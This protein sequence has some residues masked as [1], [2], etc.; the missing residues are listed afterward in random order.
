[1]LSFEDTVI[2]SWM[3]SYYLFLVF[4]F[5]ACQQFNQKDTSLVGEYPIQ[6]VSFTQVH[7]DDSFWAPR[8][9][10]HR[11]KTL[12]YTLDQ[13]EQTG[14]IRNFQIAAGDTVGVF[15]TQFPFDDSDL[16][17]I[18][19][20]ASY[21]LQ[22]QPDAKLEQRI[23]SLI[24]L[25]G[26][27][28]E[29][30]GYLYT[31][32]TIMGEKGHEWAGTERWVNTDN[33]SHELYNLGHLYEA[34]AA[35]HTAT[36]K[37]TLLNIAL[38]SA[39]LVD[40][41]FGWGKLEKCPGHQVIEIGLAK[42]YRITKDE[43]YLKLAQFFLD[44]R[45]P[46][47]GEYSQAHLKVVEQ[48]E[49][50]GHAVRAAYMY[51]GMADIAALTGNA[52]YIQA[53]DAIWEDVVT[54]KI[55]VTGGIGSTGAHEGFGPAY[56]LPNFNAYCETC[57]SIA[58]VYWNHR[59]FLMHGEGKYIDVMERTLYNAAVAG[60]GLSGDRFFYPNVLEARK[61]RERSPWFACACCP[62]SVARFIPS[63]AGYQYGQRGEDI[64]VNLYVGGTATITLGNQKVK[65]TQ[66][67]EYPFSGTIKL[68]VEPDQA[69][70]FVLKLRIPG[71][72]Q[73]EIIPGGLYQTTTPSGE[74]TLTLNGRK[75]KLKTDQGY[76]T[77]QRKWQA[78][79]EV[80]LQLPM[81]VQVVTALDSVEDDRGKVALQ[82]GPL[83]YC[84]EGQDQTDERVNNYYLTPGAFRYDMHREENLLGGVTSIT[85][86]VQ[87]AEAQ[88]SGPIKY[89]EITA[90]AIPYYAWANRTKDNMV[91]WMA[92]DSAAVTPVLW[93]TI[94]SQSKV[95]VS[96]DLK[97]TAAV[98]D[99]FFPKSSND[100]SYPFLHWWP[101]FGQKEWIQ[102]DFKDLA[103]I[104]RSEIYWF[105][106]SPE[107]GCRIPQNYQLVYQQGGQWK[108]VKNSGN[109]EIIKDQWNIVEFEPIETKSIR[110][111]LKSQDSVSAG[112]HE[113]VIK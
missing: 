56:H 40:R 1:M 25:I 46:D 21:A 90:K 59:L 63:I 48:R 49:A 6:P 13:C 28:Q 2:W 50:V 18:I 24:R 58:N 22:V 107:G 57:A 41:V 8:M 70:K 79:D 47:K 91:V 81:P 60:L 112:I 38:K 20:G 68:F 12:A 84:L 65:L 95:S 3:K 39:D 98:N 101:R 75:E 44:V 87:L 88:Q 73:G 80:V 77:L 102:Y 71:W 111:E 109:Y 99:L 37:S 35:H 30:D 66:K 9:S 72:A 74:I 14:R 31:N 54:K 7:F 69:K 106:D 89:T 11:E 64:F 113:W 19:E 29:E 53:I 94:A 104:S 45:G 10:L 23:D 51:A 5:F 43:R 61:N 55:Y 36:G 33:L 86:P 103:R 93:P 100:H 4:S 85:F 52:Q 76:V 110:L 17:K 83:V 105:D 32:R 16:Y 67:T 108:K 27:A 92:R 96:A 62:S 26:R 97:S 42:L 78:G 15:C 82:R 34:A